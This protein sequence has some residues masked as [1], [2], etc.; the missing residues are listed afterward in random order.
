MTLAA[1]GPFENLRPLVFGDHALELQH[2]LIF[3]GAGM[4]RLQENRL[5]ALPGKLLGQQDLIGILPAQPVRRMD[6]DSLNVALGGEIAQSLKP[7]RC[8]LAPLNPSSSI[9]HSS[10]TLYPCSR[11][12]SISAAV[13]LAIV[14]SSFCC[15]EDTLA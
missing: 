8:R 5:D 14:F 10:G 2:Q 11:A 4:R 13:W 9:T 6:E 15:S 7:G 1:A 3:R 12:N